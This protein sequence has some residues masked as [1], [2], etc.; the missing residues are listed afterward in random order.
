MF[1]KSLVLL[2]RIFHFST[3]SAHCDIPCGIYNPDD[4]LQAAKTML[5]MIQKM[6]PLAE[7]GA[8]ATAGDRNNFIRMSLIKEEHGRKCKHELLTLWTD[9]F[10]LEHLEKVPKLHEKVWLAAKQVSKVKQSVD[11]EAAKKLVEMV[12]EIADMFEKVEGA[13]KKE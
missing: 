5:K 1:Q 2:N 3:V 10:K 11:E 12:Q 6:T 9:Y 13:P 7:K 4:A 8:E